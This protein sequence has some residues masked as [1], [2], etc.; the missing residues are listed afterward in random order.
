MEDASGNRTY[1]DF[2]NVDYMPAAVVWDAPYSNATFRIRLRWDEI[3]GA[4]GYQIW[5]LNADG[6][7]WSVIKTLGDKNNTLTNNQGATTAY[8]NTGL[9]AGNQ[10]TY[11]IRAFS[12]PEDGKKVFGAYSDEFTV[13]AMPDKPVL[14]ATSTRADRVKLDWNAINGA[15]GYI[16][17]IIKS[18]TD[19]STSYTQYHLESGG[20]YKFRVRAYTEVDGK[21]TFGEYSDS[22][23]LT[24][25]A[26]PDWEGNSCGANLTWKLEKGVLTISGTGEMYD[27]QDEETPWID[28]EVNKVVIESG[29]TTIGDFAFKSHDIAD[30]TLPNTLKEIG[31]FAFLASSVAQITIPDSVTYIGDSAFKMTKLT[32]ITLPEGLKE[33]MISTFAY[34]EE[35]QEVVMYDNVA[36]IGKNAFYGCTKLESVTLSNSLKSVGD[37]AFGACSAIVEA[38]LPDTVTSMGMYVFERCNS[39]EVV[40]LPRY[41]SKIPVDTFYACSSLQAVLLPENLTVVELGAF[42]GCNALVEVYFPGTEEQLYNIVIEDDNEPLLYADV[43]LVTFEE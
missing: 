21:K 13:A 19:G 4:H 7:T 18:V 8:S 16:W 35:L 27:F 20:D 1:S 11:K 5:R 38:A 17:S 33:I 23:T 26:T 14:T 28:L 24:I 41:L 9:T 3:G 22:V 34:C 6:E 12:I 31:D 10:Y 43:Y 30:F 25:V 42:H 39:L 37:G 29:V 40:Y 15:A 36:A 32:S 2:S